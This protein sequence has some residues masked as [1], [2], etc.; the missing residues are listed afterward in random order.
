MRSQSILMARLLFNSEPEGQFCFAS[1]ALPIK[2][3]LIL[4]TVQLGADVEIQGKHTEGM[5]CE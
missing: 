1:L 4:R 5:P 3:T 2:Q